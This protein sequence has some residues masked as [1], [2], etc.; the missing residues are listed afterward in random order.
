MNERISFPL[1]RKSVLPLTVIKD[2]FKMYFHE[3]EKL[4]P[5]ERIFEEFEMKW[6]P[7]ARKSVFTSQNKGFVV[8]TNLY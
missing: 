5:V 4:L 2:S 6:F 7:V 3:M 8:K 1:N